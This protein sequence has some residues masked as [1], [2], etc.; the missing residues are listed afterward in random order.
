MLYAAHKLL[1]SSSILI[2]LTPLFISVAVLANKFKEQSTIM[3]FPSLKKKHH[4]PHLWLPCYKT[5]DLSSL[6]D[7]GERLVV[8]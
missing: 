4:Q 2:G 8:L 5:A 3:F 1:L 7:H 6:G